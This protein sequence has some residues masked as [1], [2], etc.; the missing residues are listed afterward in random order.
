MAA[1]PS[2]ATTEKKRIE[3]AEVD[4]AGVLTSVAGEGVDFIKPQEQAFDQPGNLAWA[5]QGNEYRITVYILKMVLPKW[6]RRF[7]I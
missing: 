3:E 5:G 7:F 1:T 2:T 6:V 4:L